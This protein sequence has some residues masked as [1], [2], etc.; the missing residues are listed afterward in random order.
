[1]DRLHLM[2]GDSSRALYASIDRYRDL[3][4]LQHRLTDYQTA[5]AGSANSGEA[6]ADLAALLATLDSAQQSEA[7]NIQSLAQAELDQRRDGIDGYLKAAYFAAARA[8][9]STL[10][11]AQ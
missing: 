1:M 3:G 4:R 11:T 9:D 10:E 8:T 2:P 5:L 6:G 7:D